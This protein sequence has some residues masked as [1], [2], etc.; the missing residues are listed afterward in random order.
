MNT[1]SNQ[2]Q[3]IYIGVAWPYVNGDIHIG[4]LT[5]LLSADLC[6]KYH[7]LKGDD[8]LMTSGSDCHGT[9]TTVQ[10][11]KEGVTPLAI[12]E[13]YHPE[14]LKLVNLYGLSYSLYTKTRTDN[15]AEV[16]QDL[17]IALLKNGYIE[18]GLCTQYYSAKEDKFLPDRYVE[19][20]CP[21]CHSK[22]QRSDQ[23]EACGR[24]L[25]QGELIDPVSKNTGSPVTLKES[26]QYFILLDK[27]TP[28][29]KEYISKYEK[30]Y[31]KWVFAESMGWINEGLQKRAITR[32][33][34]WGIPLPID[35]IPDKYKLNS[36]E[37]KCFYVWFEAVIGYLSSSIE[38]SKR[39]TGEKL[40]EDV[41]YNVDKNQD[42]DWKKWWFNNEA[43]H[44]YFMGQDNLVFHTLMWPGI[45]AGSK[46]G[47]NLP[48]NVIVNKFYNYEGKK[49]SK[50]RNWIIDSI[51]IA[52]DYGTDSIRYHMY[53]T[54]PE[55]KEGNF[56]WKE[57]EESINS[58]LVGKLGNFIHRTLTFIVN[59]CDSKL[60]VIAVEQEVKK[61]IDSC[62]ANVGKA[63]EETKYSQ[64]LQNAIR[65]VEFGNQYFDKNKVWEVIKQDRVEAEKI[66]FNCLTIIANLRTL[67]HPF[68]PEFSIKLGDMLGLEPINY[69]VGKDYW[70]IF[71]FTTKEIIIPTIPQTI[72]SRIEIS[73]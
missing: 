68:I 31:R 45:L 70:N 61:Q 11:D 17:F 20:E 62:Y 25:D 44:Y 19:G 42:T 24:M 1:G 69:E 34:D 36:F 55:N 72:F 3:K 10:A 2:D 63:I 4:H 56:K 5:Y 40:H 41:V 66:L 47:Y 32:D 53:K 18:K 59:K 50:S 29:L 12:V 46:V 49:F 60:P 38:W 13:R 23:C 14:R 37:G 21:H 54:M 7:R 33:L 71:E 16:T 64:A 35:K 6:S 67:F 22:D 43:K 9:P 28:E 52:E 39:R 73:T 8:V 30:E 65:L 58:D 26:E 57:F 15:H 51:D 27:L 48:N